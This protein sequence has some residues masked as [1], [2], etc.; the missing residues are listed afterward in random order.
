MNFEPQQVT[1]V[2]VPDQVVEARQVDR[3]SR[4]L[5]IDYHEMQLI[6]GGTAYLGGRD[7]FIYGEPPAPWL[8]PV[9]HADRL[10][11]HDRT[12]PGR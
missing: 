7:K 9:P 4:P 1:P 6:P 11:G 2:Q 8:A 12:K 5:E 3:P 10:V